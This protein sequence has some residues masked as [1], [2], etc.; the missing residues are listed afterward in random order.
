MVWTKR[1]FRSVVDERIRDSLWALRERGDAS[2]FLAATHGVLNWGYPIRDNREHLEAAMRWL[3]AAQDVS[4]E[5]GV[6]AFYDVRL[7]SWGPLYPET[8][9]YIIP[10]FY[11][12]AAV[13]KD[14]SFRDR[15]IRMAN[16]LLPLQLES[17]AF[18]IGPLWPEWERR[19]IV[20][21]TGQIV[22]GLVRVYEETTE[23]EYLHSAQRAGDWLVQILDDDGKWSRFT[24]LGHIHTY[25]VRCAWA[26]LR[27]H[28]VSWDDR[29]KT[30]AVRNLKW[31]LSQ[32][33]PDGWFRNAGFTPS[34]AP[35]T[36]TIA[37]T[38]R[39]LLESGLLL[40][41]NALVDR[42]RSAADALS[43]RL[44]RDGYL[45]GRY[46]PGWNTNVRWSCLTGNVQ[47]A[48]IWQRFFEIFGDQRD[49]HA[50]QLANNSVK[51]TQ[52]I[53]SSVNGVCGGIAGSFPMYGDYEP[54]RNL[55]WAA[56]FFVD[57]LLM[58]ARY[59]SVNNDKR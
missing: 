8:T 4:A 9:G 13:S 33:E 43:G 6:S 52:D 56:K 58:E 1:I 18:P 57:S 25:N 45:S 44:V 54:Y 22:H 15:A 35:L 16:W 50:A 41:D 3:C 2:V 5:G 27:V 26:L 10:T 14:D 42:A 12:Y 19:P 23:P 49:L 48:I 46:G 59:Q 47:M 30:A 7:A 31:A 39:G 37:Y 51:Q 34:E 36:H 17:G 38:I 53:R 20:F 24:S 28:E 11:D 32:Q 21:D 29:Y 55:N 40:D